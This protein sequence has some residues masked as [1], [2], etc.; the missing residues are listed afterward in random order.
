MKKIVLFIT[1][2]VLVGQMN[3]KNTIHWITFFDTTDKQIDAMG[4]DHG[5][6]KMDQNIRE[7]LYDYWINPINAALA[8]KGYKAEIKDYYGERT[9]PKNCK[10]VVENL[11]SADDDIIVFYYVGHGARSKNDVSQYPQML[12]A[13][14]DESKC[15]PLEGGVHEVLKKKRGRLKITIGMCCNVYDEVLTPKQGIAFS[16]NH[17]RAYAE[18][19][20]VENIQK[21][22]LENTGDIIVSSS[23]KGQ[24]SWGG[25]IEGIGDFDYFTYCLIG[26]FAKEVTKSKSPSWENI[27][28]NVQSDVDEITTSLASRPNSPVMAQTPIFDVNVEG[29]DQPDIV[30]D[31]GEDNVTPSHS[32]RDKFLND[33]TELLDR[34]INV[35]QMSSKR[36]DAAQFLKQFFA[37]NASVKILGQGGN[38]VVDKESV[39]EFFDRISFTKR[40]LKVAA[41]DATVNLKG[42]IQTLSVKEHY[43]K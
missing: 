10:D 1:L 34:I 3:A 14:S 41:V 2:L 40:L 13:Q 20:E 39:E 30:D 5:V 42:E 38:H 21:L 37:K 23:D 43:I 11:L 4:V 32:E 16:P 18:I 7:K 31:D 15:I 17:G 19:S 26:N 6:G 24:P 29:V 12:L 25:Y 33:I 36:E 35:R 8:P 22:F 27:L 28:N 9:S